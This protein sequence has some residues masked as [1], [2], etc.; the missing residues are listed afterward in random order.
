MTYFITVI[1][2]K[3]NEMVMMTLMVCKINVKRMKKYLILSIYM[4]K[5]AWFLHFILLNK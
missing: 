3:R 2:L 4:R 5:H 1:C